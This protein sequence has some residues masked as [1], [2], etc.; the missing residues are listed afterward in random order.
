MFLCV[1]VF[2]FV[3]EVS[4]KAHWVKSHGVGLF[5]M[6]SVKWNTTRVFEKYFPLQIC[7]DKENMSVFIFCET[8]EFNAATEFNSSM[9]HAKD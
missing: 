5:K 3:S 4:L 7:G 8:I 1:N 2:K 9:G 6:Q